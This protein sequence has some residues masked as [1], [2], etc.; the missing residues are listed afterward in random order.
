VDFIKQSALNDPFVDRTLNVFGSFKLTELV[1]L[2]E[3]RGPKVLE[4]TERLRKLCCDTV[5]YM[6]QT[7]TESPSRKKEQG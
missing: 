4:F 3:V 2:S 1:L 6:R 7:D 5:E